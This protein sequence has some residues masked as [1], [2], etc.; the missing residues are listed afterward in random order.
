[1]LIFEPV[2]KRNKNNILQVRPNTK[3]TSINHVWLPSGPLWSFTLT[4][5][6][7]TD[8]QTDKLTQNPMGI[9]VGFSLRSMNTS[10]QFYTTHFLWLCIGLGSDNE[11][12]PWYSAVKCLQLNLVK[13]FFFNS[14]TYKSITYCTVVSV[15]S[16]YCCYISTVKNWKV[17]PTILEPCIAP[18]EVLRNSTWSVLFWID[19]FK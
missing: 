10:R 17:S 13:I 15:S 7:E 12:T 5:E 4:Q 9:C 8:V 14:D 2:Y 3:T 16:H 19:S 11:N 18:F 6:T 1:M